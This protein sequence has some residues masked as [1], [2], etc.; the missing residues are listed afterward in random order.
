MEKREKTKYRLTEEQVAEVNH[1]LAAFRE[2]GATRLTNKWPH[3]GREKWVSPAS[4][5]RNPLAPKKYR[6]STGAKICKIQ[7]KAL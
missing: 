7:Y 1:R 3:S 2:G 6:R 5:G 4:S